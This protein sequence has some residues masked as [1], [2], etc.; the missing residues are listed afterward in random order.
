MQSCEWRVKVQRTLM[1]VLPSLVGCA[2]SDNLDAPRNFFSNN[3]IG[4]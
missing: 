2:Y 4:S 3:K 1:L